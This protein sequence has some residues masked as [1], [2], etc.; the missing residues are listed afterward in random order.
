[1]ESAAGLCRNVAGD[2][3]AQ[4]LATG[5]EDGAPCSAIPGSLCLAG[6]GRRGGGAGD[7]PP[8]PIPRDPVQL[9]PRRGCPLRLVRRAAAGAD[10]RSSSL[11]LAVYSFF[12]S[13]Q[14]NLDIRENV[15]PRSVRFVLVSGLLIW[16][17][18]SRRRA[19][20]ALRQA[21]EAAEAASRAKNE[22]LANVSHE[23]RTPMNAILGMTD[24]ALDT[25]LTGEQREY[26]AIVKSSADALLKVINDL[27]DFAKIEAG[28][29]ELDHA[30]FSLRHVLGETLRR[31]PS[32][33]TG[34][35][36]SWPAGS[37]RTCPTP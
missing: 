14:P 16:L 33:P 20:E 29:L 31:W 4:G 10:P 23:I 11:S 15:L 35:G 26:L 21:K 7:S 2:T 30:D 28:K 12:V 36:W 27:L 6:R 5:A 17:V 37:S 34:R 18:E 22:F 1:M 24:L 3:F 19:A 25:P 32:A 8:G 13:P 9:V